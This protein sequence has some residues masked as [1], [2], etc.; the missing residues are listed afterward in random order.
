M[1]RGWQ[2]SCLLLKEI[3]SKLVS[4]VWGQRGQNG[5]EGLKRNEKV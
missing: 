4:G 2:S 1:E 5:N 3:G